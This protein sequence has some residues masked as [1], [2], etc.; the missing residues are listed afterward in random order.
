MHA[1]ATAAGRSRGGAIRRRGI[2]GALVGLALLALTPDAAH[3]H[4]ELRSTTP[5][6]GERLDEA[7]ARVVLR[8]TGSVD[9][10]DDGVEVYAASGDRLDTDA[11][12]HPDG[13]ATMVAVDLPPLDDGEYVVSWQ[14][15]SPDGHPLTG[16]FTFRVASG[17]GDGAAA[18]L[19]DHA[20]DDGF[21]T[22]PDE[23]DHSSPVRQEEVDHGDAAAVL[24]AVESAAGAS[25]ALGAVY[26]V[27]RLAAFGGL[28]VLVGTAAFVLVL[29][30]AGA[31]ERRV[32][33]LVVASWGVAIVATAAS[34]GL[35]GAY[36]AGLSLPR[37]ARPER[38][39]GRT[40]HASGPHVGR[41]A[42]PARGCGDVRPP[43]RP[44]SRPGG[45]HGRAHRRG[46]D[47]RRRRDRA[48][49]HHGRPGTGVGGPRA[50]AHP[51]GG[52]HA[53]RASVA[54]EAIVAIVV[55]AVTALLVNAAPGRSAVK[56]GALGAEIHHH[57]V[58]TDLATGNS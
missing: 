54:A 17:S 30:P 40:R 16:A 29:W 33:R 2:V 24:D 31:G 14:T 28:S 20:S 55:L 19:P 13:D 25:R 23:A 56:H 18:A 42:G 1:D 49:P 34:I 45:E 27:A 48:R 47:G 4:T 53:L 36:G 41:A 35:Q 3:A 15:T 46:W 6:D 22:R 38:R 7:P 39:R 12:E 32:R 52:V 58:I 51:G 8:F 50:A 43:P 5:A 9:I 11:P 44:A 21:A 10:G 37:R 26:G 57:E